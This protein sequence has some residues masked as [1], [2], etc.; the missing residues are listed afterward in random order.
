VLVDRAS[1]EGVEG[2]SELFIASPEL[3]AAAAYTDKAYEGLLH[4]RLLILRPEFLVVVD[5]LT[6]TDGK[7]HTFDWMYH[8]RGDR[9]S[10]DVARQAGEAPEG[11]GFEYIEEVR[12]G[13][14]DSLIRATVFMDEDRVE[15]AVNGDPGSEVLVG[16]GVGESIMDR[17][18]L[19]FVT[20]SGQE[21]R[22]AATIEPVLGNGT[23]QIEDVAFLN[24]E[25]N[26][27]LIRIHKQ[28]GGEELY[29]YDPEGTARNVEGIG[30]H[31][32][33]LCLRREEM[34]D[35][36]VLAEEGK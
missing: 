6:A 5:I 29:A 21:A 13:A 27:Y 8:N 23:A 2:T 26:G 22:F 25:T 10:S 11:Q 7:H 35:Y 3:S 18:P 19:V 4:R 31:S 30:T 17:V 28:D 36:E 1:Q 14:A 16:T 20:R 33:L 24:H 12:R 15:V 32:K 34:G 9:I